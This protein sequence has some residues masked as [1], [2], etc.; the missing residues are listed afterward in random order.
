MTSTGRR[1][2][3]EV[4][5]R[6]GL[7]Q[8]KACHYR[9]LSRRVAGYEL[10]QP[11][12]DR[13]LAERLISASQEVPSF[14]YR[15]MSAWLALDESRVRRLWSALK[16]CIP[17]KRARRRRCGS[18]I[19]LPGATKPNSVWSYDFV[20]DQMVDG[21]SLKM[22]CV[23]DEYTREC[24]AIEVAA[25]LR[26]QD[27]I[28]TLSRLMRLHGKPSHVRSDNGAEF[29][30]AKVMRWFRDASVGPAFIAPDSSMAKRSRGKLQWQAARRTA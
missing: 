27:G 29:T 13:S 3:L 2:A 19:R 23:I 25:S 28:L 8:R 21:R 12:K 14:G 30:A 20:H 5:T 9:G 24:L 16:L 18:D 15:R 22:L 6:R 10:L 7:S 26:S 17:R 1:E 11:A 4:L